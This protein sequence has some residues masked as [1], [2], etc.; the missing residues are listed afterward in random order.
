MRPAPCTLN[1]IPL[2]LKP[3]CRDLVSAGN[4]A[5]TGTIV[6]TSGCATLEPW[7]AAIGGIVGGVLFLPSSLFCLHVLKIDDPVDAFTVRELPPPLHL[8]LPFTACCDCVNAAHLFVVS[9][10]NL[11]MGGDSSGEQ[12]SGW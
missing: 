9:W 6:I 3:C 8:I 12:A 4:G 10:C 7:A 2:T 1:C 5:L 11:R